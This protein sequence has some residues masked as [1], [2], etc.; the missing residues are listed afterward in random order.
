MSMLDVLAIIAA[1]ALGIFYAGV[2]IYYFTYDFKWWQ[3]IVAI[4][5]IFI[6]VVI[7]IGII[8]LL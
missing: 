4:L 8:A 2:V 6:I 1:I 7:L 5:G 3:A